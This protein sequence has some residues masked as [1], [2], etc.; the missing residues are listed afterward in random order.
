MPRFVVASGFIA[1]MEVPPMSNGIHELT[2]KVIVGGV[3]L[4]KRRFRVDAGSPLA[5]EKV[6]RRKLRV[7][8]LSRLRR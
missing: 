4:R 1:A 7:F 5:T 6:P 3:I 8:S 2:D